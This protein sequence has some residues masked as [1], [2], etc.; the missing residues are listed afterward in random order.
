MN[1]VQCGDVRLW[2]LP[3]CVR[4]EPCGRYAILNRKYLPVGT[5][6]PN[7]PGALPGTIA[8]GHLVSLPGLTSDLAA[9]I[10]FNG[11]LNTEA[12]YLYE[13]G[14]EAVLAGEEFNRFTQRLRVLSKLVVKA[15]SQ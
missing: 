8:A 2:F 1:L 15:Q 4:R 11:S 10:S 13:S 12:I 9:T 5:V 3:Y 6:A 7:G 14:N